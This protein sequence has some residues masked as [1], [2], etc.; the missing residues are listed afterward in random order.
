MNRVSDWFIAFCVTIACF[1]GLMFWSVSPNKRT[2]ASPPVLLSTAASTTTQLSTDNTQH[3]EQQND[4]SELKQII[5]SEQGIGQAVT[6]TATPL[7]EPLATPLPTTTPT[8]SLV[9]TPTETPVVT[10]TTTLIA[11][12][13]PTQKTIEPVDVA[14]AA[15]PVAIK[16]SS[17]DTIQSRLSG[18]E[19]TGNADKVSNNNGLLAVGSE[20]QIS[21]EVLVNEILAKINPLLRYP[22]SAQRRGQQGEVVVQFDL[23]PSG[24]VQQLEIVSSSGHPALDREAIALVSRA[25]PLPSSLRTQKLVLPIVF[26][27]Q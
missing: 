23:L 5:Q 22:R 9:P 27:L 2:S 17:S 14:P 12:V 7:P 1:W 15:S 19:S 13:E 10:P 24:Q 18:L 21:D 16:T 6:P 4:L 26:S 11:T 8:P 3:N 25:V 20:A